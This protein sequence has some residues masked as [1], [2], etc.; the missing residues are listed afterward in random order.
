MRMRS[1]MLM[2]GG[3][4]V[5]GA[6]AYISLSL[7]RSKK[8]SRELSQNSMSGV[9]FNSGGSTGLR[10]GLGLGE[11]SEGVDKID[12]SLG[13]AT[14]SE[15]GNGQGQRCPAHY[16]YEWISSSLEEVKHARLFVSVV[17]VI[18]YKG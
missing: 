9:G 10:A 5:N 3:L 6:E 18:Y 7:L 11:S 15:V 12:M 17:Q 14:Q 8:N 2:D 13:K 16:G 4:I 1:L